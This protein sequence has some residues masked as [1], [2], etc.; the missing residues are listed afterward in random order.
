[1]KLCIYPQGRAVLAARLHIC[2][3]ALSVSSAGMWQKWKAI[4]EL[5]S[6]PSE[7]CQPPGQLWGL[8]YVTREVNVQV[9]KK[10]SF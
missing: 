4:L 6:G 5:S 9:F 7:V 1:M 3:Y 8:K 2:P 10:G